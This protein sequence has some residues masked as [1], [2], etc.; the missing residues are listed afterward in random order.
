MPWSAFATV[1]VCWA[2]GAALYCALPAW[3]ALIV[4]D[5]ACSNETLAPVTVQ[6][7]GDPELKVTGLPEPP[8]VAVTR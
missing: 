7:P 4:Q 6:T 1:N 8:P 3:S 5:P 2:W